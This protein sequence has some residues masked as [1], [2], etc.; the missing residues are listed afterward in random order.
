MTERIELFKKE[1][2]EALE[3]LPADR[4]LSPGDIRVLADIASVY[5]AICELAEYEKPTAVTETAMEAHPHAAWADDI[6]DELAGADAKYAEYRKSGDHQLLEMARDELRH[7]GIYINR[8]GMSSDHG[9]RERLPG[10]Q[11]RLDELE[12]MIREPHGGET[13]PIL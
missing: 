9:L 4:E 13:H 6:A 5:T 8:A 11:A 3:G 2:L 1:L 12:R 10:Y 7:A